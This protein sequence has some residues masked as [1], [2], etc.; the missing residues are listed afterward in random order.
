MLIKCSGI[1]W[2]QLQNNL[3][4]TYTTP[5]YEKTFDARN[6]RLYIIYKLSL[7]FLVKRL[8]SRRPTRERFTTLLKFTLC[9]DECQREWNTKLMSF[10]QSVWLVSAIAQQQNHDKTNLAHLLL[11]LFGKSEEQLPQKTVGRLLVNS[12]P[13]VSQQLADSWPTVGQLLDGLL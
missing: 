7:L 3:E 5:N 13:T 6:H 1:L 9:V 2:L 12:R 4:F 8:T 10:F 11:Q